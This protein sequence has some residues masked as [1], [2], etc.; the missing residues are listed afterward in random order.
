MYLT[1]G[2]RL[3]HRQS[4]DVFAVE[5]VSATVATLFSYK[6]RTTTDRRMESITAA[7]FELLPYGVQAS[8]DLRPLLHSRVDLET[9]DGVKLSGVVT[10]IED[11][12]LFLVRRIVRIPVK[13]TLDGETEI[14]ADRLSRI[15]FARKARTVHY[16]DL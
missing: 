3:I 11:R 1:K 13:I 14:G 4:Q 7:D 6:S 2:Q 12:Q 9:T 8:L 15:A 5:K 16:V 10:A